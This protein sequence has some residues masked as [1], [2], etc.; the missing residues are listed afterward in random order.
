MQATG[1]KRTEPLAPRHPHLRTAPLVLEPEERSLAT[2]EAARPVQAAAQPE[3]E[4]ERRF[5]ARSMP[6]PTSN[7]FR[8]PSAAATALREAA[9][10][11]ATKIVT[12]DYGY[13]V[14]ELKRIFLTAAVI[15]LLL[16]VVAL[17]RR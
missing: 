4:A 3:A 8:R 10:A 14:G 7:P 13:V 11:S 15:I 16:I 2:E 1:R 9:S 5:T 12:T 17:L 6:A